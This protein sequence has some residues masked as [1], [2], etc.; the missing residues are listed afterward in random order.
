MKELG[1]FLKGVMLGCV[2]LG[3]LALIAKRSK[4]N[5]LALELMDVSAQ[6]M[7]ACRERRN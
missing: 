7:E 6:T 3:E 4:L 1:D 2:L 5:K